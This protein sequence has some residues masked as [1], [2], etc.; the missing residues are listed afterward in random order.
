MLIVR[1]IPMADRP[2]STKHVFSDA[3]MA[4]VYQGLMT[5]LDAIHDLKMVILHN[6][7]EDDGGPLGPV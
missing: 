5:L 1:G 6:R 4:M 7:G 3:D 2:D